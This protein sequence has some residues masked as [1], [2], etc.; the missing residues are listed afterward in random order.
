MC[1]KSLQSCPTICG[2]MDWIPPDF[3]PWD[4]PGN[5]RSVDCHALLQGNLPNPLGKTQG[6]NPHLLFPALAC[7]FLATEPPG[8]PIN[9]C[10]SS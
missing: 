8:K 6:S 10:A 2:P 5:N 9:L 7:I 1:A 3:C 4:S